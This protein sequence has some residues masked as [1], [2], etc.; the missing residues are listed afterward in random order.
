MR[1]SSLTEWMYFHI[2]KRDPETNTSCPGILIPST[3][4]YRWNKPHVW[5]QMNKTGSKIIRQ[6]KHLISLER[7]QKAMQTTHTTQ[8]SAIC[9]LYIHQSTSNEQNLIHIAKK[10]IKIFKEYLQ[11]Q[12]L[13]QLLYNRSKGHHSII[14][15]FI[16]PSNNQNGNCF[17]KRVD[18]S[19]LDPTIL[20]DDP[21]TKYEQVKPFRSRWKFAAQAHNLRWARALLSYW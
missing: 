11:N 18:R 19:C 2:W 12:D 10:P 17:L 16:S 8:K 5:Y 6:K 13:N 4:F 7:L 1:I 21:K 3:V 15:N 14:Q 9:A 20:Y